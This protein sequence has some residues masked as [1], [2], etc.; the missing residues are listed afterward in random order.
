MIATPVFETE[1]LILRRFRPDDWRD[2]QAYVSQPEVT[3]YDFEYPSSEEGCKDLVEYFAGQ[4]GVWAVCLKAGGRL[5][6]HVVSNRMGP[7]EFLNW[8][9]GFI[10][11]PA[12]ESRGYA[13]EACRAVVEHTFTAL[14]AHRIESHC[15]PDNDRSWRLLER[16]GMRREGHHVRS[17]FLR[18]AADGSPQWCDS[19]D[20][21][22][23]REEWAA[24]R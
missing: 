13:T 8:D 15:H 5:I 12:Y 24:S 3:Q 11:S 17:V 23:L 4:E 22:L 6:G 1:R 21:A 18:R 14:G 19:L 9:L 2:L 10:F 20:Y 7:A 16:L